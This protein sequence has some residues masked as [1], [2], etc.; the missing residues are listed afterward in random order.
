V[1]YTDEHVEIKKVVAASGGRVWV[2]LWKGS[3]RLR[4]VVI[5]DQP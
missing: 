4:S 5:M 1:I 3:L 2:G